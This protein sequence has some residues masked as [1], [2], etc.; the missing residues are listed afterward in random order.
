M[1]AVA[2]IELTDHELQTLTDV[3]DNAQDRAVTDRERAHIRQLHREI[4]T[5]W[6]DD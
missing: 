1:S 4:V 2:E 5:Q 6:A 3:L